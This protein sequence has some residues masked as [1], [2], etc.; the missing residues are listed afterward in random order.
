M[1]RWLASTTKKH[2]LT[3]T[4]V[5]GANCPVK[6]DRE[7]KISYNSNACL[8]DEDSVSLVSCQRVILS[9]NN[10]LICTF[11]PADLRWSYIQNHSHWR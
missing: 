10:G 3:G 8:S 11:S 1:K 2:W 7:S 5:F 6:T 9:L 4:V